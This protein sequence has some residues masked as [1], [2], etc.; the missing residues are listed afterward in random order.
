[1]REPVEILPPELPKQ[2]YASTSCAL[3]WLGGAH[4]SADICVRGKKCSSLIVAKHARMLSFSWLRP[5]KPAWAQA[6]LPSSQ[7]PLGF[8]FYILLR[9]QP[10]TGAL[11]RLN[12]LPELST[13]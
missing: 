2:T 3:T 6:H 10:L 7:S 8:D 5:C 13:R 4:A 9:G 12:R 11:R 1:M